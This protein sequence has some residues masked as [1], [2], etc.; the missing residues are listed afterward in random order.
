MSPLN[1]HTVLR[2]GHCSPADEKHREA[3][4][5]SQGHPAS[6]WS[7]WDY[8]AQ[9]LFIPFWLPFALGSLSSCDRVSFGLLVSGSLMSS[10]ADIWLSR[11]SVHAKEVAWC[12][13]QIRGIGIRES[14][15]KIP[16][17]ILATGPVGRLFELLTLVVSMAGCLW[18]LALRGA[19]A[20]EGNKCCECTSSARGSPAMT[21]LLLH[22]CHS[23]WRPGV[24][25]VCGTQR[26]LRCRAFLRAE[27]AAG[28]ALLD[29]SVLSLYTS[30]QEGHG[31]RL[32]P[33]WSCVNVLLLVTMLCYPVH[34]EESLPD[35]S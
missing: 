19:C 21:F 31:P 35:L 8:V 10:G 11:C 22:V 17:P 27:E 4:W 1:L 23:P 3:R 26:P 24:L 7:G 28:S 33:F 6:K 25:H 12:W 15:L 5:L 14:R 9:V 2:G 34:Q 29:R 16:H 13:T 20:G 30:Q 32:S 18:Y